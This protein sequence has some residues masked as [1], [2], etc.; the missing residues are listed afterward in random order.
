MFNTIANENVKKYV[1]IL[2]TLIP[3]QTKKQPY[4]LQPLIS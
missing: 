4:H 1:A 3:D 2:S